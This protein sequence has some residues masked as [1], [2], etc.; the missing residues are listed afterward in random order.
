MTSLFSNNETKNRWTVLQ[1]VENTYQNGT[2]NAF[3]CSRYCLILAPIL[4]G[5]CSILEYFSSWGPLL[6]WGPG[7]I[8]P[9][10]PPPSRW[11]CQLERKQIWKEGFFTK[12]RVKNALFFR[13]FSEYVFS[14]IL[15][16]CLLVIV[17]ILPLLF[18]LSDFFFFRISRQNL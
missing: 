10:P 4:I 16:N 5:P 1:S 15:L 2:V 8:A 3:K 9:L 18:T 7:Q 14:Y 17:I 6:V 13:C 11:P 12:E